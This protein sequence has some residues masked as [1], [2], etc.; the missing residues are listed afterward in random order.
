MAK[1]KSQPPAPKPID[2]GIVALSA[3]T[4]PEVMSPDAVANIGGMDPNEYTMAIYN[5]ML[6]VI[7]EADLGTVFVITDMHLFELM[8]ITREMNGIRGPHGSRE[9]SINLC[10]TL[11]PFALEGADEDEKKVTYR[12]L[13]KKD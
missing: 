10:R 1:K 5:N 8:Q 4:E 12:Q 6:D 9:A 3:T 7:G 13:L 2:P 11:L